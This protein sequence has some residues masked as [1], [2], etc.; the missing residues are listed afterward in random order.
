MPLRV[1]FELEDEEVEGEDEEEGEIA[2]DEEV[3]EGE[4]DTGRELS[5]TFKCYDHKERDNVEGLVSIIGGKA[6][7]LRGMAETTVDV[8]CAKFGLD[9]PCRTHEEVLLPYRAFYN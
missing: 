2:S 5:R 3:E 1:T 9:I 4:E 6:M 8:V 7:T